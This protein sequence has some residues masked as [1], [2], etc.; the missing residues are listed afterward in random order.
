MCTLELWSTILLEFAQHLREARQE[1]R[2]GAIIF[3]HLITSLRREGHLHQLEGRVDE[4]HQR[5]DEEAIFALPHPLQDQHSVMHH[6]VGLVQ[7]P[8]HLVGDFLL[9]GRQLTQLLLE[10]LLAYDDGVRVQ[11]PQQQLIQY[12][13]DLFVAHQQVAL[14][15]FVEVS[16]QLL[17]TPHFELDEAHLEQEQQHLKLGV[18]ALRFV[19]AVQH[20]ELLILVESVLAEQCQTEPILMQL[21]RELTSLTSSQP[22]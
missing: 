19:L 6:A 8:R 15:E 9:G 4:E 22:L 21:L 18:C 11:P 1:L 7:Q 5:L 3:A 20:Q 13:E 2:R 14:V 12:L 10:P 16:R 17:Q